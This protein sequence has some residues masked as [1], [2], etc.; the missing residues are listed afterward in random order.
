MRQSPLQL[1]Q[2][3]FPKTIVEARPP[4]DGKAGEMP[5]PQLRAVAVVEQHQTLHA[6]LFLDWD[7]GNKSPYGVHVIAYGIFRLHEEH[8]ANVGVLSSAV[9]NA[10]TLLMSSLREHVANVSARAPYGEIFLPL[11]A[12]EER[13]IEIRLNDNDL[14]S[15]LGIP[16][17][18]VD[19]HAA[20]GK[21]KKR[22]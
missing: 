20:P 15:R 17:L 21:S 18:D 10:T 14:A 16:D 1:E 8:L 9:L 2:L 7:D 13:D 22:A 4:V 11:I 12:L 6:N 19:S 5:G 3:F